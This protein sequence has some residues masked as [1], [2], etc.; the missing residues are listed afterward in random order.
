MSPPDG[1][2]GGERLRHRFEPAPL[3]AGSLFVSVAL[4]FGAAAL[5]GE[6]VLLTV[7]VPT[8]LIG[9]AMVGFVRVATRSRRR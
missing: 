8:L 4:W 6:H 9:L 3:L 1:T 5:A 2:D 7:A